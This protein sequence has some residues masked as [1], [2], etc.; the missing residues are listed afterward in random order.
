MKNLKAAQQALGHTTPKFTQLI[1]EEDEV[2]LYID[3]MLSEEDLMSHLINEDNLRYG[4]IAY[5]WYMVYDTDLYVA[6]SKLTERMPQGQEE[7][8]EIIEELRLVKRDNIAQN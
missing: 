4:L 7:F 8:D 3:N 5:Q 1:A 6:F 2:A